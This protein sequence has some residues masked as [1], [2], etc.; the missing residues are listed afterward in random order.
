VPGEMRV[1]RAEEQGRSPVVSMRRRRPLS[2]GAWCLAHSKVP[3]QQ[4]LSRARG[5]TL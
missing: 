4:V 3:E 2:D 5:Q 1:A